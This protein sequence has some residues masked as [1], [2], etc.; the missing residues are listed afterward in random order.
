[1]Y[2]QLPLD[3]ESK[4]Y[5]A[6]NINKEV[7]RYTPLPYSIAS[8]PSIFQRVIDTVLQEF[9][10]VVA[11]LEDMLITG[12]TQKEHLAVSEEVLKCLSKA[13]L[14][15]NLKKYEFIRSSV[16]YLGHVIEE[17]G[18]HSMPDEIRAIQ[19]ASTPQSLSELKLYLGLLM[20]TTANSCHI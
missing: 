1:M 6:I 4:N 15:A 12:A 9:P 18:L 14:Q 16:T 11:Y 20:Y 13:G 17:Q 2:Q 5:V 10:G 8:A 7:F 19:Q 3:N